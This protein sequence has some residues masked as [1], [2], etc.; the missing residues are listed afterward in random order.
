MDAMS[1]CAIEEN[2]SPA[3]FYRT[4]AQTEVLRNSLILA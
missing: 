3:A 1:S 4:N 2:H